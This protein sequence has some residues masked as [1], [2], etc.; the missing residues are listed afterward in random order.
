MKRINLLPKSQQKELEYE[1]TFYSVAV[2]LSA[3]SAILLFGLLVQFGVWVYLNSKVSSSQQEIEQLKNIAN[4]TENASVK[5]EIKKVNLQIQ[6]FSYLSSKIP[7]WSSVLAA[8]VKNVPTNV[9]I[10]QFD[11]DSAKKEIKIRGYSPSRD[12]VIDLYNNINA[13]K[14]H[15]KNINYPLENV[16][17]PTDVTF[18]FTFYVADDKLIAGEKTPDPNAVV[19]ESAAGAAATPAGE[20]A[21]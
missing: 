16:T 4:K 12:L 7:Q 20:E 13:D 14:D 8:F 17:K 11:V 6:N 3:A 2:A 15:F 19:R 10:T 21:Q 18:N 1:R 5:E 9:K